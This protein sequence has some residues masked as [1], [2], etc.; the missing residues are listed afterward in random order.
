MTNEDATPGRVPR[1]GSRK[2]SKSALKNVPEVLKL[3][4][5]ESRIE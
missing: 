4:E 1:K 2:G 5:E 3:L